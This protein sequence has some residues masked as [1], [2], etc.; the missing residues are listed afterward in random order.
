MMRE[1]DDD[2]DGNDD[3]L[4]HWGSMQACLMMVDQQ[5][6][7]QVLWVDDADDA[8]DVDDGHQQVQLY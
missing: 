2:D 4:V 1:H 6:V 7:Y 5:Q 8:A 3:A